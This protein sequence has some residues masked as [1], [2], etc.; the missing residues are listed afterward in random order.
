[1]FGITI[2]SKPTANI[3]D[4]VI[5]KDLITGTN[6]T[7]I[8]SS[9]LTDPKYIFEWSEATK[10]IVGRNSDLVTN[11]PGIYTLK[12]TDTSIFGCISD[13]INFKTVAYSIPKTV[14]FEV[15]NWFEEKQTIV[16]HAVPLLGDGSNLYIL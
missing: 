6:Q 13:A 9:G 11:D 7:I 1:M 10:G 3:S 15:E 5:C 12:I 4:Q 8:V 14:A 16:T 2:E